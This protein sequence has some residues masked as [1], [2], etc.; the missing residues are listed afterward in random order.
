MATRRFAAAAF[1]PLLMSAQIQYPPAPVRPVA[2]TLHGVSLTDPYRWLEDDK[3]PDTRA[4]VEA[5]M[6]LTRSLLDP[7]PDRAAFRQR[8]TALLRVDKT[9][10]PLVRNGR[11][12]YTKRP[13]AATR[14]AIYYRASATSEEVLLVDPSQA[15]TG[16]LSSVQLMA[17]S[18]DGRWVAY[19]VREG[20]ADEQ[21]VRFI[22]ADSREVRPVTLPAS[23]YTEVDLSADGST[24]YFSDLPVGGPR[25]FRCSLTQS[26]ARP[27]QI[28]GQGLGAKMIATTKLSDDGRHLVVHVMEGASADRVS[29]HVQELA[30]GRWTILIRKLEH[31]NLVR[32]DQGIAYVMTNWNAPRNRIYRVDLKRPQ[33]MFWRL[34]VPEGPDAIDDFVLA[35]GHLLVQTLRNATARLDLYS[36]HGVPAR[37]LPLPG[38]GTAFGLSAT[39]SSPQVF[40]QYTSLNTPARILEFDTATAQSKDWARTAAPMDSA[41]LDVKQVWFKSKDGTRVPMFLMARKGVPLD[42]ARPT[43]LYAY[44]GF[45]VSITP[46]F[47]ANFTAWAER[48]GVVAVA[49]LR[50]GGEFGESWHAAGMLGNKQNVFDDYIAAAEWLIANRYTSP[51]KLAIYGGSNGG[52]LVGAALTQRPEL[53]RAVVCSV[54]LLDMVRYHKFLIAPLWIPEY[55]SADDPAQFAYL[56]KYSPYHN[57]KKGG[58]YPAVLFVTGD[59]DTRVAPLHARKMAALL[60]SATASGLPV[61]LHYEVAS[62]HSGGLPVTKQIDDGA[63]ML[64]FLAS[65]LGGLEPAR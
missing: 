42:G 6:K 60:Q 15:T 45:N 21:T 39:A 49:N 19:G 40:V 52:L 48:G 3:A 53:Y 29:V 12:F 34:I 27:E 20:G 61:L 59:S 5:Q 24:A 31:R 26:G 64:T 9:D 1:L 46:S 38:L 33:P 22:N 56:R 54:P 43:L 50:G 28:F 47:S 7:N 41:A 55:G 17:V 32:V 30:T 51:A 25:V 2:D 11:Y 10:V 37:A 8:L 65:Q 35:G 62:G 44:G 13:A 23:R 57:V 4:F 58:K 16:E 18:A 36:L 63:D 14:E